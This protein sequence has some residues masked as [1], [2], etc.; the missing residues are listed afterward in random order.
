KELSTRD[1]MLVV[2]K[3]ADADVPILAFS[4]GEPLMRKDFFDIASYAADKG[5]YV[6][7]ATNGTL[8]SEDV[9][10]RMHDAGVKFV[11]ISL[12]GA[13]AE[14]HDAFRGVSGAF[15]KT[16][17]GIK[18]VVAAGD[19]IFVDVSTT[20]TR[21]NIEEVPKIIELCDELGVR[22]FMG[23]NFVPSGRGVEIVEYDLSPEERETLLN[24][25]LDKRDELQARGSSLDVLTTAPQF[26]RVALQRLKGDEEEIVVPTHFYNPR[27][28]GK[29]Q[30]L[31]EF[32]GGCG[33]GRCY[34]AVEPDGTIMPCVF[35]KL[36]LGNIMKVDFEEFWAS[37]EV[38]NDLRDRSKLK[39]HCGVCKFRYYCGGCRARAYGYTGDYLA[40]DPGC[41]LNR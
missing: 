20:I 36:P 23:F 27:L 25:L 3:L 41:I 1:A 30:G 10:A 15:E 29:L 37:N 40:G 26:A 22:W 39:G 8:I 34:I 17:E 32:I 35:F 4:G 38:L 6:G 14:T 9:A 18:N 28:S 11:Q 12:D 19:D 21:F 31:A 24:T 33:A 2:D 16:L 13:S 5:M 7:V